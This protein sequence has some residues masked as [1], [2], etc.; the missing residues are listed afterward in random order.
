MFG[1]CACVLCT[2][3]LDFVVD[4]EDYIPVVAGSESSRRI[5]GTLLWPIKFAKYGQNAAEAK[6]RFM[7]LIRNYL[8]I[9][10]RENL[11]SLR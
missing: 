7:I 6:L 3:T 5:G 2:G 1:G 11:F 9:I 4:T 8:N 10:F